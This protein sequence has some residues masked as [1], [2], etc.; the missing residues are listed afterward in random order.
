MTEPS[1]AVV[2]STRAQIIR[3][4]S[5]RFA[6]DAYS[7]VSLDDIVAEAYVLGSTRDWWGG[8]AFGG[9][10]VEA[11]SDAVVIGGDSAL[12]GGLLGA[13]HLAVVRPVQG[14]LPSRRELEGSRWTVRTGR[15]LYLLSVQ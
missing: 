9:Q 5:H 6:V 3:A 15:S 8:W 1:D 12:A 10:I 13:Q 7:S 14:P 4:A 2:D 11:L